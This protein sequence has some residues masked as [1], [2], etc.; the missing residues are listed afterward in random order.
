MVGLLKLPLEQ[1][2]FRISGFPVFIRTHLFPDALQVLKQSPIFFPS[3][4]CLA[5]DRPNDEELDKLEFGDLGD[6]VG[7]FVDLLKLPSEQ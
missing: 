5:P 4:L 3:Q 2:Y 7:L 6:F 1:W